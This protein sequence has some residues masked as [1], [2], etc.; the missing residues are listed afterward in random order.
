MQDRAEQR[1]SRRADTAES[2]LKDV[3]R[4]LGQLEY[5][6]TGEEIATEYGSDPIDMPNETGS[7]GSVFDRLATEEF[8][9]GAAAR[10]AIYGEITGE[11]GDQAEANSERDLD[12]LN[13]ES[14]GS[15]GDA[16]SESL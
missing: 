11:S 8:E 15:I 6:V 3:E 9:N 7:L 5:P 12:S 10:E 16:G 13:D 14:Q 2:V 4:H 1:K